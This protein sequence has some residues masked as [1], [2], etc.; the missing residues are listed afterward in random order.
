MYLF[1]KEAGLNRPRGFESPPF[2]SEFKRKALEERLQK[3]EQG[4]ERC[5][6]SHRVGDSKRLSMCARALGPSA[7]EACT[8]PV[9][10]EPLP[11]PLLNKPRHTLG[12]TSFYHHIS[13]R[14]VERKIRFNLD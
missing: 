13:P 14:I 1:A 12:P 9:R 2:R 3:Y 5:D 10:T 4:R 11:L 6:C 8:G 7:R